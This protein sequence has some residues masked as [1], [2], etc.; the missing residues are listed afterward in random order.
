MK[1]LL[2]TLLLFGLLPLLGLRER[3]NI[4]QGRQHQGR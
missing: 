4:G 1:T 3:R 2:K